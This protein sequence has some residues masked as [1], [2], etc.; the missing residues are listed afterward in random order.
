MP[1]VGWPH[2]DPVI[3]ARQ[4]N[5]SPMGAMDLLISRKLLILKIKLS[6][7][8]IVI[9]EKHAKPIQAEGT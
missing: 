6:I 5:N 4:V 3:I 8:K 9:N 2:K 1:H 7:D